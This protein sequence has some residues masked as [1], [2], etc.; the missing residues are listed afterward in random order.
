M[1]F[2]KTKTKNHRIIPAD[3]KE[4]LRVLTKL[5]LQKV[6]LFGRQQENGNACFQNSKKN[7][8]VRAEYWLL[9]FDT[10]TGYL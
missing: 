9:H 7:V 2:F 3:Q 8:L 6:K 4:N 5:Y 1:L 10:K